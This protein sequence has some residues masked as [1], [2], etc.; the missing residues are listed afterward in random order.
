MTVRREQVLNDVE[1]SINGTPNA[2]VTTI[3]V[4]DGTLFPAYG[5]YRLICEDEVMLVTARTGNDLTVTRGV[6]GTTGASHA[7]LTVIAPI[8][9]ANAI[10]QVMDDLT[11]GWTDRY[12]FRIMDENGNILTSANFTWINQST[13][14]VSDAAWGGIT[15]GL[16]S[17]GGD[18]HRIMKRAAP[19]GAWKLTAHMLF[20]PGYNDAGGSNSSYGALLVRESDTGKQA[21]IE[22]R[23]GGDCRTRRYNSPTSYNSEQDVQDFNSDRMWL[24]IEDDTSNLYFRV[25]SDGINWF[26]T[27]NYARTAFMA[28]A[29]PDEIG[30]SWNSSSGE[31]GF[32]GHLFAWIVE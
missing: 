31:A 23:I 21:S 24:Q 18:S 22:C 14:S 11:G 6:D 8:L 19:S 7:N 20:G 25:S 9:T 13:T 16:P 26:D 32:L 5:D 3:T 10:D 29:G 15:L 30:F 4:N 2:S 1:A 28:S 17:V 27:A 12:P